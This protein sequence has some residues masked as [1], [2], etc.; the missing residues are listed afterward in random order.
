MNKISNN[1]V[2]FGSGP[3]AAASLKHILNSFPIESVVTRRRPA[4]HDEIA[5]V[6]Q[7]AKEYNLKLLFADSQSE[8]EKAATNINSRCGLVVDYGIIISQRVIDRFPLGIV[9]SHFSFLPEWRGA[10]PITYALLSGQKQTAVC[11]MKINADLDTGDIIAKSFIPIDSTETNQSLTLKLIK[12]SNQLIDTRL[13]KYIDREIVPISQDLMP[14]T[15]SKKLIKADGLVDWRKPATVLE[16]EIRAYN[17]WPK[18]HCQ[19]GGID[20]VITKS[21]ASTKILALGRISVQANKRIFIGC[22][23]GSLEILELKPAA[24]KI[25]SATAFIN[26][27]SHSI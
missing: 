22:L 6:E 18:S 17:D 14:I 4:H 13:Q 11:L 10:D 9:N 1:L 26:G 8:L 15:Y 7:I 25:M 16:R 2:F 27:Y 12:A 21:Q 20:V 5:P 23:V 24:K 3:V 19:I